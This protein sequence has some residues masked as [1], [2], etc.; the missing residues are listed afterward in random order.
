MGIWTPLSEPLSV[1]NLTGAARTSGS[2]PATVATI[3]ALSTTFA[4]TSSIPPITVDDYE[5]VNADGQENSQRD[6]AF[7]PTVDFEKE[8]LDTTPKRDL[9]N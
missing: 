2:V 1:Q 8:N 4:S 5:D 3:T 7:F 6:V 9:L